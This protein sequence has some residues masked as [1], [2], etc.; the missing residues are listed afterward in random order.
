MAVLGW[1][2]EV[3]VKQQLLSA[4]LLHNAMHAVPFKSYA[5]ALTEMEQIL[6][7]SC[8]FNFVSLAVRNEFE[9]TGQSTH[10]PPFLK[11]VYTDFQRVFYCSK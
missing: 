5:K 4:G 7:P 9:Y 3:R 10:F 1:E 6:L 8:D 11:H 2:K